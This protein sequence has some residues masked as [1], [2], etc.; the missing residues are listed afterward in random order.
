MPTFGFCAF[1]QAHALGFRALF[2]AYTISFRPI[3]PAVT[4]TVSAVKVMRKQLRHSEDGQHDGD[5][6][7]TLKVL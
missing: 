3:L 1:F 2:A 5:I 7:C 6:S 4:A